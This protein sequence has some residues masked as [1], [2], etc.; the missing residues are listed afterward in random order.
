[1]LENPIFV[2]VGQILTGRVNLRAN[3]RQSYDVTIEVGV[4]GSST[5]SSNTLDLKNPYFRYT[6][7]APQPPPGGNTASPSEKLWSANVHG[8]A[9]SGTGGQ[10]DVAMGGG[11]MTH[12]GSQ[13]VPSVGLFGD[14]IPNG[15]NGSMVRTSGVETNTPRRELGDE[16]RRTEQC[17]TPLHLMRPTEALFWFYSRCV[18]R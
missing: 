18:K 14:Y 11:V 6:G 4:D 8:G 7:Q 3:T 17:R 1:M 12:S 16:N 15:L 13:S 10:Q 5:R 2:R 9:H